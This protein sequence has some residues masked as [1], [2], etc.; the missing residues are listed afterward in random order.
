MTLAQAQFRNQNS[1]K[2]LKYV[3]K[4]YVLFAYVHNITNI[5]KFKSSRKLV[6]HTIKCYKAQTQ[7]DLL[8]ELELSLTVTSQIRIFTEPSPSSL[9]CLHPYLTA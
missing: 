8:L 5:K 3:N 6:S 7:L 2:T 1:N 9:T 4:Y